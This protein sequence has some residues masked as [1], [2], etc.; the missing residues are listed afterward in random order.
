MQKFTVRTLVLS[1]A[2]AGAVATT[3]SSQAATRR[4]LSTKIALTDTSVPAPLCNPRGV[5][6]CGLD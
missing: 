6:K 4:P 5:S 2:V 1:L 3:V